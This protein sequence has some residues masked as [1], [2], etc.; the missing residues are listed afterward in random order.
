MALVVG[1]T[2]GIGSGKT[3]VARLFQ[4]RGATVV[5]TD[6]IS[7]ELTSAHGAAMHAIRARFGERYL[8]ASG[9]LDRSAMR[10]LAF[11]D[12]AARRDLESILHPLIREQSARLIRAAQTPY[13]LFVVPLLVETGGKRTGMDRVLV[14]DCPESIQVAR[15]MQRSGLSESQVRTIMAAQATREQR[16]AH[17]DDIIDNG[18]TEADLSDQVENLHHRYLSL[19]G[20]V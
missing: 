2:G 12:A 19:A 1:V 15:T 3:T 20:H 11:Q 17:A 10:T 5:D 8:E 9:A 4:Q 7:H 18:S 13:V 14:V 6:E 16:L